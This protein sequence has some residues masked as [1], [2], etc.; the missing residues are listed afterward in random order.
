MSP[1]DINFPDAPTDCRPDHRSADPSAPAGVLVRTLS[2]ADFNALIAI[3]RQV[4]AGLADVDCYVLEPEHFVR[5]HLGERGETVGLFAYDRLIAFAMLGSPHYD[6]LN[7]PMAADPMAADPMADA[8][9]LPATERGAVAHLASSMV[10]PG[11]RGGGLHKWLIR[12]RLARC[13]ALGRRHVMAMVSPRNVASWHNLMR[14]GLTIRA[15]APLEGDRLR[16]ILY[17]DLRGEEADGPQ[18]AEYA[19]LADLNRQRA[20][21]ATGY[22][23]VGMTRAGGD[24]RLLYRKAP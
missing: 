9:R 24:V 22:R 19:S 23:G 5:A 12:Y 21:L 13:A 10:L 8:L 14:H 1:L 6:G 3:R 7:R 20:L 4:A 15:I 2:E 18:G 16:Y 17:R 11:W